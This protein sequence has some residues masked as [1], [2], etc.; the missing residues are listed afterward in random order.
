LARVLFLTQVLPY[1]LD[2]GPK[3]RAYYVLRHLAQRHAVTLVAF[4]RPED[5]PAHVE[6]LAQFCAAGTGWRPD[7]Q[8]GVAIQRR[9]IRPDDESFAVAVCTTMQLAAP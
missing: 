9:A 3:L 8:P 4:V 2:A 7:Q 5:Q 6:H 1:P